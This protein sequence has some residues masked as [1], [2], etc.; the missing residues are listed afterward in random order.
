MCGEL[1]QEAG[2]GMKVECKWGFG[3]LSKHSGLFSGHVR[4]LCCVKEGKAFLVS[5]SFEVRGALL[6]FADSW[7]ILSL[8]AI[9]ELLRACGGCRLSAVPFLNTPV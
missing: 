1:D 3:K 5:F 2:K 4:P 8:F 7:H 6:H 9:T